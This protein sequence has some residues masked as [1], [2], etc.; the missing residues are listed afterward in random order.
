MTTVIERKENLAREL[1]TLDLASQLKFSAW[2]CFALV[3]ESSVFDFLSRYSDLSASDIHARIVKGLDGVWE[4]DEAGA[5][6]SDLN[7]LEWDVDEINV[8][9]DAAA[10]GA[11]DLLAALSFLSKWA[12]A[13]STSDLANCAE[14]VIN[15]VDYLE[16]FGILRADIEFPVEQEIRV[17]EEFIDDLRSGRVCVGDK[18][19]C[20]GR[21]LRLGCP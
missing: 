19:E 11:L 8:R 17:Q 16:T 20:Q 13:H 7:I 18:V 21:L 2:C 4:G 3:G 10:Q 6:F 9:D 14:Q 5:D 12:R 1:A 15:R